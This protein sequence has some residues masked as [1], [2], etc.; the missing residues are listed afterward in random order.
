MCDRLVHQWTTIEAILSVS[1]IRYRHSQLMAAY[2]TELID[3]SG[4]RTACLPPVGWRQALRQRE[5]NNESHRTP[6]VTQK[7]QV[8]RGPDAESACG[9]GSTFDPVYRT[10]RRLFPLI[11]YVRHTDTFFLLQLWHNSMF[12]P[13]CRQG[14]CIWIVMLL[15]RL[16]I[17]M[18]T[19]S[20][21]PHPQVDS[22]FPFKST[23]LPAHL[24]T[25]LV[26]TDL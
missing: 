16:P 19:T 21:H 3:R 2:G 25:I 13:P 23:K 20:P 6:C 24:S 11:G 1:S 15:I 7:S 4:D 9:D 10:E 14:V 18:Y 8:I 12:T 26:L 17:F 22:H 5:S